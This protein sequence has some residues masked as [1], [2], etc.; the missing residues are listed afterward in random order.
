M[1]WLMDNWAVLV[2]GMC[3]IICIVVSVKTFTEEPTEEQ[4]KKVKEWLKFA[5]S[6]AERKLGSGT[7]Q[8]K[9]RYVY[10][11][12]VQRFGWI[13]KC[14]TFETFS[15]LVDESLEWLNKQLESNH[16]IKELVNEGK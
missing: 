6:E 8:L 13:A 3:A 12:F 14:I 11:L 5:V 4:L 10:D 7:G 2:A 9:L 16:K 15:L 1:Y